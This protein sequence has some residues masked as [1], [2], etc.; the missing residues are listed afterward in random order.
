MFLFW[1]RRGEFFHNLA[2]LNA[3]LSEK[4]VSRGLACADFDNDGD[5]DMFIGDRDGNTNFSLNTGTASSPAFGALTPNPYGLSDIGYFAS[6]RFADIDGDGDFD[7]LIGNHSG[8]TA[9]FINTGNANSPVFAA[10]VTD[11]FGLS[12]FG[13]YNVA[14]F[15]DI[16]GDGD[17]DAVIGNFSGNTAIA[18]NTGSVRS[19]AFAALV[20]NPYGLSNV[21][22]FAAPNAVDIDGDGDLDVLMGN[23]DG[24]K[25][26]RN[27]KDTV[28]G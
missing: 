26:T 8:N 17:L 21:S 13:G 6:P 12:N 16:D 27:H 22:G 7:A 28:F 5:L 1:N 15:S 25:G 2:H 10:S 20:A 18:L 24:N 4:H 14:N 9:V 23:Y 3:S 11:P 19:P